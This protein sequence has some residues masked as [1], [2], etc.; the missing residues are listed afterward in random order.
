M[1][2]SFGGLFELGASGRIRRLVAAVDAPLGAEEE[3]PLPPSSPFDTGEVL[4][5]PPS[6]EP[7]GEAWGVGGGEGGA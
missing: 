3:L 1:G 5:L 4:P 2:N 7:L 6:P